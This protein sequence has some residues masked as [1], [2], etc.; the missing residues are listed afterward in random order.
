MNPL[1]DIT[2]L[3]KVVIEAFKDTVGYFADKDAKKTKQY[4]DA[5]T[6]LE[7]A[8]KLTRKHAKIPVSKIT[9]AAGKTI[10]DAWEEADKA[11]RGVDYSL[12]HTCGLKSRYWANPALWES[13][14]PAGARIDLIEIEGAVDEFRAKASG[15]AKKAAAKE[16]KLKKSFVLCDC[17]ANRELGINASMP[18]NGGAGKGA[19]AEKAAEKKIDWRVAKALLR[20]REQ[21]NAKWPNRKKGSDGTIGDTS[22]QNS[23]SDHNPWVDEGVVTALDITHDPK[24]GPNAGTLAETIRTSQDSRVKYI[25]SNGRIANSSAI[26]NAAAWVWRKYNGSNPHTGHCHIS[27]KS[28]KAK[29]DNAA[30]WAI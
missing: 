4:G 7:T 13:K 17:E 2:D 18:E 25:I 15:E 10:Q 3:V 11:L 21:V 16:P 30:D 9:K 19:G 23:N 1:K 28:A 27:V 12:A 22:H 5:V 26:G 24:T 8:I 6:A 20:L 29:Y 14:P